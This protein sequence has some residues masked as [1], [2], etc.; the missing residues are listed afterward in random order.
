MKGIFS[1]LILSAISIQART[2]INDS[3]QFRKI[4]DEVMMNGQ[5]YDW[6]HDLCKGVG[7]RLSGSPQADMAVRW[8]ESEMKKAGFD[9]VW[10]QEVMVPHWERG[11]K[12]YGEIIGVGQVD[13]LA[14]G[15]SIATPEN[16][17]TANVIEVDDFTELK[18]LGKEKVKG[19]IIFFNHI[20]PQNVINSFEGYGEAGPY[21]WYGPDSA[22]AY[23]AIASITRSVG[24]SYD[25]FPHTGSTGFR[26]G[27][28]EIPCVAISAMDADMLHNA[29]Q[30]NSSAEFK[31]ILNCKKLPDVKSY[32]VIG[33]ITGSE[34]P[35]EII[36]VGGHLDSWDV[37][38]GAH[39]D[40]AGCVQ[41]MEVV[42]SLKALNIQP[43]RTIRCILFMNEENGNMGG[44]TYGQ[45]AKNS[46]TEKHIA[47][48]ES[49]AGG[50]SPR[51]FSID[52]DFQSHPK[53]NDLKKIFLP[54]GVYTF[55]TGHGGTDIGPLDDAGAYLF[56]LTPDS[57]RYMDLH[58]TAND[59][60]D[61]V[62]KR[63]L[64]MG[65]ATMAMFCWWLS[66]Y[67][68]K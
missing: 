20:F 52:A 67:G 30:K 7:H 38:E 31:M 34:F 22:S 65:A 21:R 1:I 59:T 3:I 42:R 68:V 60:F 51:G 12:E 66:E 56:G 48:L 37:G 18:K 25:D 13:I 63:E 4:F 6:L 28:P 2:Q 58:H 45:Y 50:F 5:S 33:E 11:Q 9:K 27:N 61:K 53:L 39:D 23:G 46:T 15:G 36:V 57:Q 40:G 26:S 62:N 35:N 44:K 55:N 49:D 32:S 29:L 47:A 16:G 41:A 43:K 19:K 24:S 14:L 8:G 17:I 10:L 64:Q 54:Y